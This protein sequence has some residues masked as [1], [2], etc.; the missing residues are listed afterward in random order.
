[1]KK[2]IFLF[3]AALLFSVFTINAQEPNSD[4]RDKLQL[5]IKGGLNFSN[6]YDSEGEEFDAEGKFGFVGGLFL[7][8]PIGKYLGVQPEVLYSQKGYKSTGSFLG[9]SY[10]MKRTTNFIDVPILLQIKPVE[11]VTLLAGPQYSFMLKRKDEFTGGSLSAVQEEEFKN[12]DLRNNILGVIGGADFNFENL[13]LGARVGWDLQ[14][15]FKDEP[16]TTPRYRN[17]W[18]QA[19]I[20][21]RF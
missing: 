1:M 9:T 21:F 12:D 19:T 16:S 5:G 4:N 14:N 3:S 17:V 10:E 15:N 11:F 6:I 13:V 2:S 18:Y 7:T 8:I 20:G